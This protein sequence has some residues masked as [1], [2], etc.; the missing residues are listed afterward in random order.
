MLEDNSINLERDKLALGA[1]VGRLK[2]HNEGLSI[3]LDS[4]E[5]D[6]YEKEKLVECR[7]VAVEGF[8]PSRLLLRAIG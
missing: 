5:R 4:L 3:Q 6:M 2:Q 1:A 8:L 7:Y